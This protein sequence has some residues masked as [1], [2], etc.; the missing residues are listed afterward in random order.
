MAGV[1]LWKHLKRGTTYEVVSDDA[2]FQWSGNNAIEEH[3]QEH[4]LTVYRDIHSGKVYVRPTKEFLDG[5]FEVVP[6]V[7]T[8]G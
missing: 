7:P 2:G 6:E 4:P 1:K 8:D 5:R 3:L